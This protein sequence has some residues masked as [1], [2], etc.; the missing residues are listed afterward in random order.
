M[1]LLECTLLANA[2]ESAAGTYCKQV[3][4]TTSTGTHNPHA[5]GMQA[6]IPSHPEDSMA[7]SG[8]GGRMCRGREGQAAGPPPPPPLSMSFRVAWQYVLPSSTLHS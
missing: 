2:K 8:D 4:P 3:P 7:L 1:G 5:A 6:A